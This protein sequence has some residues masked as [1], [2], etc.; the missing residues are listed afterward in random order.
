MEDVEAEVAAVAA[1]EQGNG[2]TEW[3]TEES[4]DSARCLDYQL[5]EL[6]SFHKYSLGLNLAY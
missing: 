2:S 6:G 3:K 5:A 1:T 4:R